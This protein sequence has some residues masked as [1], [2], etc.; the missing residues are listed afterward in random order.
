MRRLALLL[1]LS[2]CAPRLAPGLL[3]AHEPAGQPQGDDPDAPLADLAGLRAIVGPARVVGL[4]QPGPGV[5]E[6]TRLHHRFLRALVEQAG[7]TGLALDVDATTA[8]ALDRHVRGDAV[9]LDAT[10]LKLG[11]RSF[12]TVELRAVLQWMRAHNQAEPAPPA[13][14]RV[15]GLVPGDPEAALALVLAWLERA[16]PAYVPEARS[17]LGSGDLLVIEAVLARLDERRAALIAA[18]DRD[19]WASARQQA[20]LIAQH[21]RLAVS[22]DHEAGEFMRARSV[23]WSLA[24][25]G[26]AGKL[27]VWADNRRVAAEVPGNSPSMG[28]FLRQWLAADYVAIATS[29]ADGGHLVVR[30]AETVCGARLPPPRPGS[31]DAALAGPLPVTL[32]DLRT[33]HDPA[34][35]AAQRLRSFADGSVG[36]LRVRPALAF[37][38]L[39]GLR[40]AHPAVP[41]AAGAHAGQ[42]AEGSCYQRIGE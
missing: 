19:A 18:S 31:L 27:M 15:F 3:A 24:Q 9:D 32:V 16:D 34:L 40:H 22:W 42:S 33:R 29:V 35:A 6:L 37:D 12:A 21:W 4:G 13:A 39:V 7:F 41:L 11:D 5:H 30:D 2:A 36:D 25:L 14:L 10:L 8:V 26:P 38:A 1:V 28:D 20:E 23:E 17:Q